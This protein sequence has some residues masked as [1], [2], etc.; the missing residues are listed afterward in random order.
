MIKNKIRDYYYRH[1]DNPHLQR[2]LRTYRKIKRKNSKVKVVFI[3]Q[4]AQLW[5]KIEPI[6]QEMLRSPQFEPVLFIV[7]DESVSVENQCKSITFFQ[8][9]EGIKVVAKTEDGWQSLEQLCPDYVFYQ[10]PYEHYLPECYRSWNVASY[11]RI[12]YIPYAYILSRQGDDISLSGEFFKNLY[13]FF[14]ETPHSRDIIIL[15]DKEAYQKGRK[16]AFYLGYPALDLVKE[17]GAEVK[18]VSHQF[19]ILWTPRWTSDKVL[20]GTHFFEYKNKIVEEVLA[21]KDYSLVFRP[22][23]MMFDNFVKT[24]EL[25]EQEVKMYLNNFMESEKLQYDTAALYYNTLWESSVLVTDTS[26]ILIEYLATGKPVIYCKSDSQY[27][28]N[29]FMKDVLKVCYCA[30]TWNEIQKL[31]DQLYSGDDPLRIKREK[32]VNR[33]LFNDEKSSVTAIIDVIRKDFYQV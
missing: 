31:L 27:V 14:A 19:N 10:R 8:S 6:Y 2:I 32:Y 29:D 24:G 5:N 12:C 21:R 13:F 1:M 11:S 4:M 18:K 7:P 26:T 23:P 3:C 15:R 33:V 20:G 17:A 22:H 30:D 25:T 16:K 9:I 28:E